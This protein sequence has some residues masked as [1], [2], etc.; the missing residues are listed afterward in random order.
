MTGENEAPPRFEDIIERLEGLV[1]ELES[2]GLSLDEALKRYEEGVGLARQGN[3]MLEGAERRI[4]ELQR[5]LAEP[6][7]QST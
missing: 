3:A 6:E 5:N 1:S 2:G 7:E 4:E